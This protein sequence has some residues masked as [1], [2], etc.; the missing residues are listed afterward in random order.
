MARTPL[1]GAELALVL[2]SIA[3]ATT[4]A[5]ALGRGQATAAFGAFAVMALAFVQIAIG[6]SLAMTGQRDPLGRARDWF[7]AGCFIFV[8]VLIAMAPS[9]DA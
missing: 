2:T 4:A 1:H 5:F 3:I 6:R 8:A 9:L 7:V